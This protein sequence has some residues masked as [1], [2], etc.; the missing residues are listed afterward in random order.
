MVWKIAEAKQNL[1]R[2]VRAAAGAPQQLYLRE[3]LVAVVIGAADYERFQHWSQQQRPLSIAD[4]FRQLREELGATGD[5]AEVD[6][7]ETCREARP[8]AFVDVLDE[9]PG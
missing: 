5:A 6:F 2:L 8:N 3:Q 7:G 4:R 1:S 9:L